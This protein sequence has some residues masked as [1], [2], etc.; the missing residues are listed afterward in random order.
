MAE[1]QHNDISHSAY[2][3]MHTL[4]VLLLKREGLLSLL[5]ELFLALGLNL[6]QLNY[7]ILDIPLDYIHV[8]HEPLLVKMV[9]AHVWNVLAVRLF[10]DLLFYPFFFILFHY[11]T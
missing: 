1:I 4:Y 9:F 10:F 8:H 7:G 11:I 6:F 2:T 5:V 3:N